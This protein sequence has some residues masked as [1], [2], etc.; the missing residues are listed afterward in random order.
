M[1]RPRPR[2]PLSQPQVFSQSYLGLAPPLPQ[3]ANDLRF[4]T[5]SSDVPPGR[6]AADHDYRARFWRI[7]L[8]ALGLFWAGVAGWV[9]S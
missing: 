6:S 2:E 7:A 9:L 5:P 3:A 1:S 8:P 4:A